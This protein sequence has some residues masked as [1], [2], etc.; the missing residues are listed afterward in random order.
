MTGRV[1][2]KVTPILNPGCRS[3]DYSSLFVL[4]RL[5]LQLFLWTRELSVGHSIIL[6]HAHAA[7][8]YR[9]E[10]KPVHGGVIGITLNGDWALPYDDKPESKFYSSCTPGPEQAGMSS[11]L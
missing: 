6:A 1:P 4:G 11:F 10:I 9:E 3:K 2:Q 5:S 7:K 8:I